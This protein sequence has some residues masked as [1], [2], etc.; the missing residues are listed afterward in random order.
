MVVL[1]VVGF[2]CLKTPQDVCDE[3]KTA[4]TTMFVRCD[5][6]TF[7]CVT[8]GGS[9]ATCDDVS[10]VTE[11]AVVLDRCIPWTKAVSCDDVRP[12]VMSDTV[13]G[14]CSASHFQYYE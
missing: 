13:P 10:A 7:V 8:A 9:P 5:L 3:F 12:L 4:M 1:S 11:P 6:G 14:M 2:G